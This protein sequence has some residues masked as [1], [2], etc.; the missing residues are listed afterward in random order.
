MPVIS[1]KKGI[2]IA[3]PDSAYS[4]NFR[5]RMQNRVIYNSLSETNLKAANLE[6]RVR[7]LRLRMEGFMYSPKLSYSLQLSFSKGDMD[8]SGQDN[9]VVNESPNV[10]RDAFVTFQP[11]E[12]WQF[13]FGQTKL[14][15]NRQREVS[16]GDL[17]FLDRSSVNAN[18][19]V[20]RDFGIHAYYFNNAGPVH[21]IL[22]S[23]ISTGEGR[24]A[25]ITD[26]G[27]SYTGRLEVLPLGEFT[28]GGDYFEGDLKREEKVK[29][30]LAGGM[31]FNDQARRTG[32]QLGDDL[33]EPRDIRTYIF[34]GLLKYRGYA[35]TMEYL[36][37]NTGNPVT[38]SADG[39]ISH[40]LAG[41][42][43]LIQTSYLFKNN[44]ELAAR[45]S[46]ISPNRQ[47][48][49][50]EPTEEIS[51]LGV[52]K[53]LRAHRL[54]LQGNLSYT[55]LSAIA[56]APAHKFWSVGFQMEVGI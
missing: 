51:T 7:R 11:N 18:F 46:R 3:T 55:H 54:K 9:S 15:G 25:I 56:A 20:D 16:S 37:R 13:I 24:N 23:A 49:A 32:G 31:N 28:D 26:P 1:F 14:P 52:T 47:I 34:D 19:T 42:G 29:I 4:I 39:E 27:L 36:Q 48:I 43:K 2:G 50:L 38:E 22:K 33:F 8:W 40:I 6:A 30:S 17:Q 21:Y 12:H 10:L 53:Y 44:Y 41:S 5:F 45:F 35:L